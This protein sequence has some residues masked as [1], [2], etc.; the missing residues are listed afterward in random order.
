MPTRNTNLNWRLAVPKYGSG[1]YKANGEKAYDFTEDKRPFKEVWYQRPHN[2][3]LLMLSEL[4]IVG[5]VIYIALFVLTL[6]QLENRIL[7]AGLLGYMTIAFFSFPTERVFH[8]MILLI[9]MALA[10]GNHAIRITSARENFYPFSIILTLTMVFCV[11]DFSARYANEYRLSGIRD[12]R[13]FYYNWDAIIEKTKKYSFLATLHPNTVP[14]EFYRG[15]ANY[16]KGRHDEAF[17]NFKKALTQNPYDTKTLLNLSTCYAIK[18]EYAKA[19]QFCQLALNICPT[20]LDI[21]TNLEVI[22][23][24]EKGENFECLR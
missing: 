16:V 4:S 5:F 20:D 1:G 14:I 21:Q 19:K 6:L 8:T 3:Y 24:K 7:A 15:E 23:E 12:D 13:N 18:E 2:E 22:I 11:Y 9:F 10:L 17:R